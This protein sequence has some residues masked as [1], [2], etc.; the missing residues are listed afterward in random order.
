MRLI[1]LTTLL[2][3]TS[4]TSNAQEKKFEHNIYVSGG[5]FIDNTSGDTETGMSIKMG[6]GLNYYLSDKL[7]IMPGVAIRQDVV[8]PFSSSEGA[9]NDGFTFLDVP[10]IMQYHIQEGNNAWV[11]GLGPVLSFCVK[12]DQYYYDA[13]P[14][15][16][17]FPSTD[18][19]KN[20][21]I[22]IQPSIMY[23]TGK[24]RIGI[25]GNAGL[26]NVAKQRP[27]FSDTKHIHDIVAS[28]Y[29]HF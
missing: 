26:L 2:M 6:Y 16:P 1:I 14:N 19:I 23:Q 28:I 24:F 21:N 3:L 7:S 27:N 11:L 25:E 29:Y 22:G 9:D 12:N 18:K 20:F 15:D 4:I 5:L 10:I 8:S 13:R 17:A